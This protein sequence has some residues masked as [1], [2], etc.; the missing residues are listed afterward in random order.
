MFSPAA[1]HPKRE[2]S[3][4]AAQRVN[5]H[6]M[7]S[8]GARGHKDLVKFVARGIERDEQQ[9]EAGFAPVPG[10]RNVLHRFVQRAP[11]QQGEHGIFGEVRAFA[12]DENDQVNR[13]RRQVREQPAQQERDEP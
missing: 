5:H 7:H 1:N 12:G 10:K 4:R 13:A 2:Q 11:E 3:C 6:V 9:H 8:R